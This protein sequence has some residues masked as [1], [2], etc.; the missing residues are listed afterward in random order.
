[1]F[2]VFKF[3]EQSQ[4]NY[5]APRYPTSIYYILPTHVPPSLS[6]NYT[7]ASPNTLHLS[8]SSLL[9]STTFHVPFHKLPSSRSPL[10]LFLSLIT[11]PSISCQRP[12]LTLLFHL[13]DA[14][15]SLPFLYRFPIWPHLLRGTAT[16][17]PSASS[18]SKIRT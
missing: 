3:K 9:S 14:P 7:S 10:S 4:A 5:L 11:Y 8:F 6:Y 12:L 17:G 18:S 13:S 15:R 16:H 2:L 1:M